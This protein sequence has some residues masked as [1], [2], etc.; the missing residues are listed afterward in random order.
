MKRNENFEAFLWR[1]MAKQKIAS[2]QALSELLKIDKRVVSDWMQSKKLPSLMQRAILQEVLC[3]DTIDTRDLDAA[4]IES[5][6]SKQFTKGHPFMI[7]DSEQWSRK[8]EHITFL[9]MELVLANTELSSIEAKIVE[10]SIRGI[11]KVQ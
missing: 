5:L 2:Q 3:R 10:N 4:L 11:L 8:S 7:I 6:L 9:L 1:L